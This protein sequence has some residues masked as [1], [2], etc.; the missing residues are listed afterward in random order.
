MTFGMIDVRRVSNSL[1]YLSLGTKKRWGESYL[2]KAYRLMPNCLMPNAWISGVIQA[3]SLP[4]EGI[5]LR[6]HQ[7][8]HCSYPSNPKFDPNTLAMYFKQFLVLA[9][10]AS[11]GLALPV[12][13]MQNITIT[14]PPGTTTHGNPKLLCR[15]TTR[16]DILSFLVGNYFTHAA[17][18][19]LLPGEHLL[20]SCL[21]ILFAL[22]FPVSGVIRGLGAIF[23]HS[24]F[25]GTPL[26]RA[27]R[28]EA[29]CQVVRT[30][31]WSPCSGDVV[32]GVIPP[33]QVESVQNPVNLRVNVVSQRFIFEAPQFT[34]SD[35]LFSLQGRKVHGI[36]RLPQGYAFAIVPNNVQVQE[37]DSGGTPRPSSRS[38]TSI[39]DLPVAI[40]A[41]NPEIIEDPGNEN[42][43]DPEPNDPSAWRQKS[44]GWKPD[45]NRVMKRFLGFPPP[46]GVGESSTSSSDL[47]SSFSFVSAFLAIIQ[48][49]IASST[50]I[51]RY[52]FA[53]FGLTVS[54]YLIMS[55]INLLGS[56]V[57]PDY[58]HTYTVS[59][60]IMDEALRRPDAYFEGY[61][62]RIGSPA[63]DNTKELGIDVKFM[64]E[65]GQMQMR[66]L[67]D[68]GQKAL[69][70]IY[71]GC[72]QL[73]FPSE[74]SECRFS[75]FKL[76]KNLY[77][78]GVKMFGLGS[79]EPDTFIIPASSTTP[80][81]ISDADSWT[82][83]ITFV[84]LIIG[85]LPL[86]I[87]GALSRFK[88]G[89]SSKQ[90]QG[91][92]MAWLTTG[93]VFGPSAYFA[94]T[95]V[96]RRK[97]INPET[98]FLLRCGIVM[99]AV[100]ALVGWAYVAQMLKEYGTCLKLY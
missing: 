7:Q 1:P 16:I 75:I 79:A 33:T 92:T 76:M 61:I 12:A 27:L 22:F 6:K 26:K 13:Q 18:V 21:D 85:C 71:T 95:L 72:H 17:T 44:R 20:P 10:L 82:K 90:Q 42:P 93:I 60:D 100:P 54:P 35:S 56:M 5:F 2:A 57:T 74:K 67:T 46:P 62:G 77:Q 25:A 80:I 84:S 41:E 69:K 29:V 31:F 68:S 24:Y 81:S 97:V 48:L 98:V 63:S 32:R 8:F 39:P 43:E 9:L 59:S 40:N 37:T 53:A 58:T 88:P 15:P 78:T 47:S 11:L 4:E 89:S 36:C 14:V 65:N 64:E 30:Q 19:R 83:A 52:G 50:L 94:A 73:R 91:W 87:T 34:P 28:S 3:I 38:V 86:A 55:A 45:F 51:D 99:Y 70:E 66:P 96:H 49:G 23:N